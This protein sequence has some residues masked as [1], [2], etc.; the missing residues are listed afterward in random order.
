LRQTV[1]QAAHQVASI[2]IVK[3]G[4]AHHVPRFGQHPTCDYDVATG[5]E[6]A[7]QFGDL[8]ARRKS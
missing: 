4:G 6:G 3:E 2:E 7:Q 8:A 5:F 1:E